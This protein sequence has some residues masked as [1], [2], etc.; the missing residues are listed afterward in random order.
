M[1]YRTLVLLLLLALC[2]V[3][4]LS[5]CGGGGSG[6]GYS[7]GA[8]RRAGSRQAHSGLLCVFRLP[9][10]PRWLTVQVVDATPRQTLSLTAGLGAL[11]LG[12]PR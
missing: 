4:V 3:A 6:G 11:L 10:E 9:A 12:L 2:L 5:A 1:R 8:A 7:P